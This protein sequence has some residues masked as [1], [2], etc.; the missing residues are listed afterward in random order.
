MEILLISNQIPLDEKRLLENVLAEHQI[1]VRLSD[2]YK[3]AIEDL[4]KYKYSIVIL[5]CFDGQDDLSP[6]EAV[7]IMKGIVPTLLII[8]ISGETA[9]ETERELRKSGLYFHL[10]SPFSESELRDVLISVIKKEQ[11]GRKR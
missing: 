4:A 6:T 9:L 2:S 11:M 10:T 1:D 7:R 3:K 8:A 5:Y